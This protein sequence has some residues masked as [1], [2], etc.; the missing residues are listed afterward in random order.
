MLI[1]VFLFWFSLAILFYCYIGY[2]LILVLFNA[3]AAAFRRIR[4][5]FDT[6]TLP[7]SL[8]ISAYNEAEILEN[9][10]VNTLAIDYP[11]ELLTVYFITDGS[12]DSSE[13]ILKKHPSF[14]HLHEPE[15]R[16]KLA[17]IKR[18][19][20]LVKTPVVVFSDANSILNSD[21]ISKIAAHYMDPMTGGVAGEKKILSVKTSA[22][23]KAEG[24]YWQYESFMKKQDSKFHT[25][26]GAAGELFSIR[27]DL[28]V[29]PGDH[30]IL[31]DFVISMKVCLKGFMI[32]YEPGAYATELPSASLSEEQKRK[33][34]ISA[35]AYQSIGE[36]KEALNVFK[37]PV[38]AFQYLSRRVLRWV[39]CPIMLIVL[40]I[41][42]IF[43]FNSFN[44]KGFYSIFLL[45]QIVF[46][47]SALIG[48]FLMRFSHNAR[49]FT[50]PFYF[51]FMN[52]CLIRGFARFIRKRQTVTW[53]KSER[54]NV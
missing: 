14:I 48:L 29:P 12:T 20:T 13:S 37:H 53:E 23:G 31:D 41:S 5:G 39:I 32:K 47:L 7:V 16:G 51:L 42:N 1:S 24:L 2:G 21:C 18:A 17:A 11:R 54:L 49:L 9:K 36:L 45:A 35:G 33:V 15:R 38:L 19:M 43:L 8:I 28:F 6:S 27:T 44:E 30:I 50:I 52:Y 10:I 40:L 22:V 34:R 3:I 26:V 4:P 46:Y 25:V